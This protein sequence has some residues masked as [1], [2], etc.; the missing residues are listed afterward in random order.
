M[1]LDEVFTFGTIVVL[2]EL[3]F[4]RCQHIRFGSCVQ[5]DSVKPQKQGDSVGSRVFLVARPN[6]VLWWAR[7]QSQFTVSP[8]RNI[9]CRVMTGDLD[10]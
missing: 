10:H 2:D 1:V 5:V 4:H 3:A 9:G 7:R 8:R 6:A